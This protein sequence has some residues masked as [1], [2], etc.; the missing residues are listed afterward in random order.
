MQERRQTSVQ[1]LADF[2]NFNF[3]SDDLEELKQK[4]R[5]FSYILERS[6]RKL[7]RDAGVV[8]AETLNDLAPIVWP[9]NAL[10]PF[11]TWQLLG[12][13]VWKINRIG[14]KPSWVI[15][16]A[17]YEF[18]EKGELVKKEVEENNESLDHRQRTFSML[19]YR[20]SFGLDP[21]F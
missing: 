5:E 10:E 3:E 14:Y 11:E 12:R 13:L 18:S 4:N 19:G 20:W 6:E 21:I 17:D 9:A 2:L 7:R 1:A 15:N 8:Q 16:F